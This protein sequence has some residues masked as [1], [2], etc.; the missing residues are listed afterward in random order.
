M[1][2]RATVWV[3]TAGVLAGELAAPG[4][5]P[6]VLFGVACALAIVWLAGR[7][8]SAAVAWSGLAAMALG[9]GAERMSAVSAPE[10]PPDH[11]ARLALP[12]RTALEGRIAAAPD[13]RD[14]RTVLLVAAEAVGRGPAWRRASGLV[15][16]GVRGRAPA[17]RYG[18]RL[19]VDTILRAPRN[20]E[21]PGRFDYVGTS[22]GAGCT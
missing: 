19:R 3:A 8:R 5:S 14:G 22:P 7:R 15:R 2:V 17:W 13:R 9:V 11:V 18:D 1:E 20:F 4:L 10:F 6:P 12:L 21:S 16:V